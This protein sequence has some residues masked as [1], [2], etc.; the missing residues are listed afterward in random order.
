MWTLRRCDSQV[1]GVGP[2]FLWLSCWIKPFQEFCCQERVTNQLIADQGRCKK[3]Y[4]FVCSRTFLWDMKIIQW[5]AGLSFILS[6]LV[7]QAVSKTQQTIENIS[8]HKCLFNFVLEWDNFKRKNRNALQLCNCIEHSTIGHSKDLSE[9]CF[10]PS[11][12]PL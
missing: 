11:S 2:K 6:D 8:N 12:H 9:Q 7:K 3:V 5:N 10:C 4:I 1:S